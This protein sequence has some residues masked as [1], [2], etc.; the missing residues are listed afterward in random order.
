MPPGIDFFI[1]NVSFSVAIRSAFT[2]RYPPVWTYYIALQTH[3]AVTFSPDAHS[4]VVDLAYVIDPSL[5]YD[6]AFD[7][8]KVDWVATVTVD[9]ANAQVIPEPESKPEVIGAPALLTSTLVTC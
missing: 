1:L 7:S 2:P 8:S 5:G 6:A 3:D 4:V 9:G